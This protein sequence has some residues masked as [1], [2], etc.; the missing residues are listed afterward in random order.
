MIVVTVPAETIMI[1][2]QLLTR[3]EAQ[4]VEPQPARVSNVSSRQLI[5]RE[6]GIGAAHQAPCM[7][8]LCLA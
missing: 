2:K 1:H 7:S 4:W 6:D 5:I 8:F 3:S